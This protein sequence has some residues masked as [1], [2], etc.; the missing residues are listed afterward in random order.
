MRIQILLKKI[1]KK[2]ATYMKAKKVIFRINE[3]NYSKVRIKKLEEELRDL[4]E[5]LGTYFKYSERLPF[6]NEGTFRQIEFL[7]SIKK[8]LI[9]P[10]ENVELVRFGRDR[11]G[12]YVM[13]AIKNPSFRVFSAGAGDDISFELALC[14]FSDEIT[15]V[16]HTIAKLSQ[17]RPN[18]IFKSAKLVPV[19]SLEEEVE[20][21]SIESEIANWELSEA[22]HWV[23]KIDIEG[24]EWRILNEIKSSTLSKFS[25]ILLE[26]HGLA[27]A[28]YVPG[29]T[30][31][32]TNV[33]QKLHGIFVPINLHANN[34]TQ[35]LSH[36]I[37]SYPDVLE[38]S[39]L[40]RDVFAKLPKVS[41]SH[42]VNF[43]NNPFKPDI[44]GIFGPLY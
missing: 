17:T 9:V 25:Q 3:F 32:I 14:E 4:K 26:F 12:G 44:N 5:S 1:I 20:T 29:A 16:D 24:D 22:R 31:V 7:E 19:G 34:H 11:D 10:N 28:I 40:A 27:D 39:Y 33:L 15:L 37:A 43:P 36:G 2:V 21:V 6:I 35:P 38:V 23:L 42:Q 41:M 8:Y 13:A 30:D 18:L